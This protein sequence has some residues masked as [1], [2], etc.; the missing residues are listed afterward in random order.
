MGPGVVL[1]GGASSAVLATPCFGW[2]S[3]SGMAPIVYQGWP[4][5]HL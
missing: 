2:D 3:S 4:R 5:R 1:I